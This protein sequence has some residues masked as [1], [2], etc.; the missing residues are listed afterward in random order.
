MP[1]TPFRAVWH[2]MLAIDFRRVES[3]E[4]EAP[5]VDQTTLDFQHLRS[6]LHDMIGYPGLNVR[7]PNDTIDQVTIHTRRETYDGEDASGIRCVDF[8]KRLRLEAR[9]Q[10]GP[11]IDVSRIW[12]GRHTLANRERVPPPVILPMVV[13]A[14]DYEEM[15]QA[16]L[17]AMVRLGMLKEHPMAWIARAFSGEEPGERGEAEEAGEGVLPEALRH[18]LERLFGIEY[19]PGALLDDPSLDPLPRWAR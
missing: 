16:R 13:E 15:V 11:V 1:H 5:W 6:V 8:A 4:I 19:E 17:S 9:K 3:G 14:D 10:A 2:L 12:A 18:E 7:V